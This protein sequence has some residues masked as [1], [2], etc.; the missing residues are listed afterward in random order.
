MPL[1]PQQQREFEQAV[2]R[3][4][5]PLAPT[6]QVGATGE[7]VQMHPDA[8]PKPKP[9][10][11]GAWLLHTLRLTRSGDRNPVTGELGGPKCVQFA[12]TL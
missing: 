5:T 10:F 11:E 7:E 8:R 6:G 9:E 4:S 1:P 12:Q 3:A 2:Q